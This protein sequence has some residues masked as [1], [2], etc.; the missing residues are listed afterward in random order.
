[1][2]VLSLGDPSHVLWTVP[3]VPDWPL[4]GCANMHSTG[5]ERMI[6]P[7]T[8]SQVKSQVIGQYEPL[9]HAANI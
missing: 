2:N 8:L 7:K 3:Q 5:S 4:Q 9:A 6:S 1:M